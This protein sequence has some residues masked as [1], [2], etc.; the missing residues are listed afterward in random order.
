VADKAGAREALFGHD[1]PLVEPTPIR[2]DVI[3]RVGPW[4]A[5]RR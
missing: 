1:A 4:G 2:D 5:V 3:A